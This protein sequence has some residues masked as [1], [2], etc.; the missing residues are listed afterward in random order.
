MFI[1]GPQAD[2]R[3]SLNFKVQTSTPKTG[4][5]GMGESRG[6][7]GEFRIFIASPDG[8]RVWRSPAAKIAADIGRKSLSKALKKDTTMAFTPS[9][10]HKRREREQKKLDKRIAREEE[11]F[12]KLDAD[13]DAAE[14]AAKEAAIMSEEDELAKM[15][16]DFEAE[17][18]AERMSLVAC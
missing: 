14:A 3:G 12:A 7:A 16:A 1:F 18:E 17:L 5:L 11:K 13:R 8:W 6:L 2:M 4:F 15:E 10:D 9:K